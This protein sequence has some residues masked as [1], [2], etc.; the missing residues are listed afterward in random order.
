M[1]EEITEEQPPVL[2]KKQKSKQE[3]QFEHIDRIKRTL[4]ACLIGIAAGIL[5]FYL[6]DISGK[7]IGLL[8]FML[9]LAGVVIQKHIFMLL[10][11]SHTTLGAKDWFYQGFMTFAFWFMTWTILLTCFRSSIT[12]PPLPTMR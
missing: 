11:F 7:D 3:K 6:S 5:S 4:T 10:N 1:T 2:T 9:M 8:A 12:T